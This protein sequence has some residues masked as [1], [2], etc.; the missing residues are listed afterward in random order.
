MMDYMHGKE[1]NTVMVNGQVNPVLPIRPGQVQRWRIVNASNARFYK[2]SLE[3]HTLY[4]V[5]TEGGL[6]DKPYP[7]SSLLL[8]PGRARGHA[9]QGE[10]RP[11]RTTA[12][13]RCPTAAAGGSIGQQVTLLTLADQG[14]R[15]KRQAIPSVINPAAAR[16]NP[17]DRQRP[18]DS[19]LSMGQ[20]RATSTAFPF[21]MLSDGTMRSAEIHSSL[22]HLRDL[23]DRQPERHGPPLP[24][25]RQ[26]LPGPFHH[27]AATPAYASLYTTAPAWKDVVLIP[28]MGSARILVPG[29]GL[30]RHGHVPLPHRR[31]RG[32]RHD[33]DVAHHGNGWNVRVSC[34][35]S[36]PWT[37]PRLPGRRRP[38]CRRSASIV[39]W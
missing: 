18:S 5:G 38:E 1:G 35:G 17:A 28:K 32:H 9:G 19:T 23:G 8:S 2:L 27:A 31:A 13:C 39:P 33:G 4:V 24:P 7:V 37:E 26:P 30:R 11:R 34:G 12:S 36:Q 21:E 3:G 29:D 6:L 20:G 22:G 15:V 10:T 16:I 14:S 25:A